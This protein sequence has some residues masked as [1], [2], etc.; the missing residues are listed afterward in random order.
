[1]TY[2]TRSA[3]FWESLRRLPERTTLRTK[4][5]TAVLAL[6]AVALV[7]ISVAGLSFLRSYL[8]GNVDQQLGPLAAQVE[9]AGHGLPVR[10]F[11]PENWVADFVV[12]GK[13]LRIYPAVSSSGP[14]VSANAAWLT[15]G[16]PTTVS[17][18]SADTR[19]RVLAIPGQQVYDAATG[20]PVTG[21]LVV[22]IDV[23]AEYST[24]GKLTTVDVVVSILILIALVAIGAAVI[25]ASLRPLREI[26]ETAGAIAAGDLTRRVPEQDPNTEV[27][28]L[29]RSLNVMLSQIEAAFDAQ[30]QSEDAAR[31]SESR[32]RQF[33]GD[34]SHELRTPLTAIRGFAEYYRQRGGVRAAAGDGTAA[35]PN[36]KGQL[37]QADL[38]RIMR[39]LEQESARMGILVED[40]LLLARMDQQRPLDYSPVDLLTLAADAVHD[41]RMVAPDRAINLTVGTGA[42]LLVNG[43]EV[44]LR[45]VIGNLMSNALS[46]TPAG[47]PI[48]VHIRSGN[49]AE[50]QS[51]TASPGQPLPADVGPQAW[52][53]A[54]TTTPAAVLEVT[55]QGPGLT[56]E[57]A[58]HAFE[59]FYRADAARTTGGTGLG[60]A[61]V[62]ALV[63]AHRGAVWVRTQVGHGATFAIALPLA[64]EAVREAGDED[65]QDDPVES[66]DDAPV[67]GPQW[68]E[69]NAGGP[70]PGGIS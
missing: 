19:W 9:G 54:H 21:T 22:G 38:D 46:H 62:A 42:A 4:L 67:P 2:N 39:R 17:G 43:D 32:M 44:R 8:L 45:Q 63:A 12:D 31:R 47:S 14:Q 61:I 49:M 26:E 27:G 58:A 33:M 48:D 34:A 53:G 23:S 15:S 1:M 10:D 36:G 56:Q 70:A 51:A 50:I 11:G 6:V 18:T 13:V 5:I 66:P 41:A 59:R 60:L 16:N 55:D 65:D 35:G 52:H 25:Q 40:M 30:S 68:L 28:R 69:S 37:S 7:V 20:T 29:G 24:I 57:Q 3:G 64:P